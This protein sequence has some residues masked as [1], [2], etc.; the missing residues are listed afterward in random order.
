MAEE[1]TVSGG[2]P[3]DSDHFF[4]FCGVSIEDP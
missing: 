1:E 3:C 4:R 2:Q